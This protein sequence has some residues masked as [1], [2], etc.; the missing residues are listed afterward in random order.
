MCFPKEEGGLGFSSLHDVSKAFSAKL[1]WNFRT[2]TTSLWASYMWNK[3]RRK[4]HPTVSKRQGA[5]HTWRKL[6]TSRDEIE[7]NIWWQV[8]AGNSSFWFDNW[9][10]LGALWHVENTNAREEELEVNSFIYQGNLDRVK[11]LSRLLEEMKKYIMESI[12]PPVEDYIND[13]A[14]WMG[15]T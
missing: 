8:K 15:S 1:W 5:S 2:T 3:Y 11:L 7:H 6:I 12:K 4:K 14:W 13:V 9:T 10:K